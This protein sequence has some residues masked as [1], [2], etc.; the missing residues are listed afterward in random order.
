M[1]GKLGVPHRVV[2]AFVAHQ[3][4]KCLETPQPDSTIFRTR[5]QVVSE[6]QKEVSGNYMGY[7]QMNI[8][9]K[10]QCQLCDMR[11]YSVFSVIIVTIKSVTVSSG[12]NV[13]ISPQLVFIK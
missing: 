7:V 12:L 10:H 8:C 4:S 9:P 5:Q 2:V 3:T 6:R 13:L 11:L 1:R